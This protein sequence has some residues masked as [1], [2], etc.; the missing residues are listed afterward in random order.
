MKRQPV[1]ASA[2]FSQTKISLFPLFK[3]TGF[4]NVSKEAE[5]GHE[6]ESKKIVVR[7]PKR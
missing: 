4:F 1:Y 7:F 3:E 5:E 6:I 2:A